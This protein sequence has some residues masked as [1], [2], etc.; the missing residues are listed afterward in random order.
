MRHLGFLPAKERA[1][2]SSA[3]QIL[4]AQGLLRA[5]LVK[6]VRPCGGKHCRCAK[7]RKYWH[8]SWYV[9]QKKKGSTRMKC[10]PRVM[11]PKVRQWINHYRKLRKLL[12]QISEFYWE[13]IGKHPK[14]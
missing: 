12:N 11:I 3:N 1:A 9:S 13:R 14:Y 5:S 2:R 8:K 7:S 10:V 6:M 4:H